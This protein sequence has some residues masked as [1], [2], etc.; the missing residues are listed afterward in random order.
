MLLPLT[1]AHILKKALCFPGY[2]RRREFLV[3][4]VLKISWRDIPALLSNE[5][6]LLICITVFLSGV[7]N[8]YCVVVSLLFKSAFVV[9]KQNRHFFFWRLTCREMFVASP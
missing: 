6:N 2:S 4:V 9:L 1:T 3:A 5:G 7:F 8:I